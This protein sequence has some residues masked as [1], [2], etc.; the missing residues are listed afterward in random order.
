[1]KASD[2]IEPLYSV[3]R[4]SRRKKICWK[5]N[6]RK[7][8]SPRFLNDRI[9]CTPIFPNRPPSRSPTTTLQRYPFRVGRLSIRAQA[10]WPTSDA[11]PSASAKALS[12]FRSRTGRI[13]RAHRAR[14][15][16]EHLPVRSRTYVR[17]NSRRAFVARAALSFLNFT[18]LIHVRRYHYISKHF[19]FFF[20]LQAF[21][22]FFFP[23]YLATRKKVEPS[24][25][26]ICA[27]NTNG[28]D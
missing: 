24:I 26:R 5:K 19:F 12:P 8:A 13:R 7:N 20:F 4:S 15:I 23:R 2:N 17:T 22:I 9:A 1:M 11:S 10:P 16:I 21:D 27:R 14:Q 28:L 6:W 18:R 3:D 25:L